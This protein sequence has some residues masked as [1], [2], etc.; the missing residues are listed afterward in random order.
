MCGTPEYL[1]PEIVLS[2]G[3]NGAADW[4]SLGVLIYEMSA[5]YSPFYSQS[6]MKIYEKIISM[7]YRFPDIFSEH[8][9]DIIRNLLQS[10]LSKRYGNLKGGTKDIKNHRWFHNIDW[11]KIYRKEEKPTYIPVLKGPGDANHFDNYEEEEIHVSEENEFS[12]EFESF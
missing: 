2:K 8:V 7:K 6:P 11:M 5:G 1:A 12:K 9:K 3:Y 10:D 4:W